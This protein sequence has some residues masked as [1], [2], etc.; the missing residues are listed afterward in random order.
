METFMKKLMISVAVICTMFFFVSCGG[1]S[2]EKSGE[3]SDSDEVNDS[4]ETDAEVEDSE[5]QDA[6]E[7][8]E[9]AYPEV[10]AKSNEVG[11]IAQNLTMFDDLDEEHHLSEWYQPNDPSSKLIWLIFTTYDCSPCH[12]LKEDLLEINLP[13]YRKQGLKILLI[14][15]GSYQTGPHPED[16]PAKLANYKDLYISENPDTA[17]FDLYAYLKKEE[18]KVFKKFTSGAGSMMG[19]AS[20]PTW[21]FIDAST[22]EIVDWGEGWGDGMVNS[23]KTKIEI[24][25]EDL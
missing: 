4:E 21:M 10:T 24:L 11:D 9:P 8:Q 6:D 15:N 13:E 25:F 2:E 16:E 17:N 1:S 12:V 14:F 3:N 23:T 7:N 22:M 19:G 5:V 20:Y 18:Q